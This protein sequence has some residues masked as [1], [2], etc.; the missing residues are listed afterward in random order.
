VSDSGSGI[1]PANLARVFEPFFTTKEPGK[2]TGLGL[3]IAKNFAVEHG[4][5]IRIESE[6]GRG[7][8][9]YIDL[10]LAAAIAEGV[11]Q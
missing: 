1:D 3:A 5:S 11:A 6:P 7:A 9:A 4:G 2:G 10:P 8:T